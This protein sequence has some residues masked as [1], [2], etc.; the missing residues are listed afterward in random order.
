MPRGVYPR[1]PRKKGTVKPAVK[2][3]HKG[4]PESAKTRAKISKALTGTHH[5]RKKHA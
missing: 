5:P 3:P 1:K 2:H 4:H